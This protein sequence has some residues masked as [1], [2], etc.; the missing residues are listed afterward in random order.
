M[1]R[2]ILRKSP[3][4]AAWGILPCSKCAVLTA[5]SMKASEIKPDPNYLGKPADI[6]LYY[7]PEYKL[8]AGGY[9]TLN[10]MNKLVRGNL[11]VSKRVDYKRGERPLLK[12]FLSEHPDPGDSTIIC[13]LGHY[14][15]AEGLIYYSFFENFYDEV[16]AVWFLK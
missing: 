3:P 10:S 7:P 4:D 11:T 9:A 12:D 15:Y 5:I 6:L 13:C 16:V 1:Q 2:I 14:I 8:K